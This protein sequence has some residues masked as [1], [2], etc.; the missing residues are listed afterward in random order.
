MRPGTETSDRPAACSVGPVASTWVAEYTASM[1]SEARKILEQAL[2]LPEEDRA[3]LA[4]ALHES[5]AAESQ[6]QVDSAW[7][8]EI[9]RRAR[10]LKDGSA[11]LVEIDD[12]ER[13]LA[14]VL[15]EA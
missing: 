1:T 15:E 13:E 4:D 10:S 5:L 2:A 14:K 11:V 8:D 12:V 6:E 3:Q 7:K 9:V